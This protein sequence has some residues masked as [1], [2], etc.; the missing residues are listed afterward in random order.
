MGGLGGGLGGGGLVFEAVATG[1]A[2]PARVGVGR[3]AASVVN[4]ATVGLVLGFWSS[5]LGIPAPM[6]SAK[7]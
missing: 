5:D 3:A 6:V 2:M 4:I 7:I 1:K